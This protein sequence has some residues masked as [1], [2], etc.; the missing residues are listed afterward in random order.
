MSAI[1]LEIEGRLEQSLHNAVWLTLGMERQDFRVRRPWGATLK[2]LNQQPQELRSGTRVRSVFEETKR[3]LLILGEPGSGKTI[4]LLE[5]AR[6]LMEL[7]QKDNQQPIPVLVN[8]SSWKDP[9]QSIFDWLLRELKLKYGLRAD[10]ATEYLR[11]NQLLPLLDGLDEVATGQQKACAIAIS[12]WM[13]GDL[14]GKPCGLVV[15]CRREEF[16]TVV[17]EPLSLYGAI[18][19]QTLE[20]EQITAYLKQFGLNV[21]DDAIQQDDAL[22]DLLTKPLF[23]SMFGLVA[24][25]GRFEL[26]AWQRQETSQ[27]KVSY[28]FDM[29][30]EAMMDRVLINDPNQM[31][32]DILSK[33]YGTKIPPNRAQ[34]QRSLIFIAQS[35]RQDSQSEFLVERLQPHHLPTENQRSQYSLICWSILGLSSIATSNLTSHLISYHQETSHLDMYLFIL[36]LLLMSGIPW[37]RY[38]LEVNTINSSERFYFSTVLKE[39][40]NNQYSRIFASICSTLLLLVGIL[41]N[42]NTDMPKFLI[43]LVPF[44]GVFMSRFISWIF[45]TSRAEISDSM[46]VNQGI[47]N[48]LK[49]SCANRNQ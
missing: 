21:V 27:D 47:K 44:S 39:I 11:Q 9:K 31:Q 16:E 4:M 37:L 22:L 28:L 29:Y 3:Q 24:V 7:A 48:S 46:E 35:L 15:C 41:K 5:L 34:I 42:S 36:P 6:D 49:L 25:Q 17:Q 32:S 12:A 13:S 2:Q 30:W 18:Y 8:L 43:F 40:L 1:A 20:A 45:L 33:T 14:E 10:L 23:L 38:S 26:V 19:L